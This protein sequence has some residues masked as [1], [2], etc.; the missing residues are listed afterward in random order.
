SQPGARKLTFGKKLLLGTAGVVALTIPVM[1]G[2]LNSKY[3]G[4]PL[5]GSPA[6]VQGNTGCSAQSSGT[7]DSGGDHTIT[8]GLPVSKLAAPGAQTCSKSAPVR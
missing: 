1:S 2:A 3:A 8:K 5:A 6:N 7:E 4:D